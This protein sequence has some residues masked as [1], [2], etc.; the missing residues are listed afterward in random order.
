MRRHRLFGR[1]DECVS[2]GVN[3][4]E[5]VRTRAVEFLRGLAAEAAGDDG[6][7]AAGCPSDSDGEDVED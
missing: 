4:A 7:A 1:Y 6:F 5:V 2:E 3:P